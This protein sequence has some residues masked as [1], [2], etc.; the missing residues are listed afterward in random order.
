M[1]DR[2]RNLVDRRLSAARWTPSHSLT[3]IRQIR[4]EIK[5]KKRMTFAT[6]VLIAL[7]VLSAAALAVGSLVQNYLR[8]VGQMS[9]EGAFHSDRWGLN[10]KAR[11]VEAMERAGFELDQAALQK[12]KDADAPAEEREEAA[13]ALILARYGEAMRA[14]AFTWVEPPETIEGMAPE[15]HII[16]RDAWRQENPDATEQQEADALAR[17]MRQLSQQYDQAHPPVTR[18]PLDE[19][20]ADRGA[21]GYLTEV[22]NI[23]YEAAQRAS[24]RSTWHEEERL[25]VSEISLKKQDIGDSWPDQ[26]Y[27]MDYTREEG[28]QYRWTTIVSADG[29]HLGTGSLEDYLKTRRAAPELRLSEEEARQKGREALVARY[30]ISDAQAKDYFVDTR[31]YVL[32]NGD[33]SHP[34]ICYRYKEHSDSIDHTWRYA[35]AV[36]M[37]TGEVRHTF[38]RD[39]WWQEFMAVARD[40]ERYSPEEWH[41]LMLL[42]GT[43][44]RGEGFWAW[45]T[46][47]QMEFNQILKEG[48]QRRAAQTGE[49]A[50]E[51]EWT[52]GR[53]GLP[54][55]GELDYDA[56][57]SRARE[58]FLGILGAVEEGVETWHT[59]RS[60]FDV[61]DPDRHAWRFIIR[62]TLK[63]KTDP[64]G[65]GWQMMFLKLDASSG[66]LLESVNGVVT[67]VDMARLLIPMQALSPDQMAQTAR[68]ALVSR[69]LMDEQTLSGMFV[70][71]IRS[72]APANDPARAVHYFGVYPEEKTRLNR[73]QYAVGIRAATGEV[74]DLF[75]WDELRARLPETARAYPG[76]SPDERHERMMW[77]FTDEALRDFWQWTPEQQ[78]WFSQTVKPYADQLLE[79]EPDYRDWVIDATRRHYG[80][81]DDGA[82]SEQEALRISREAFLKAEAA[83]GPA[84]PYP[85]VMRTYDVSDP[86]RP[87]W[88]VI[89]RADQRLGQGDGQVMR[90]AMRAYVIDALTGEILGEENIGDRQVSSLSRWL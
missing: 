12:I 82:V 63:D 39:G 14:E 89:Q 21:I 55:E 48:V 86:G 34:L 27:M 31:G 9:L 50:L 11:F 81:P 78:R 85:D 74:T 76:L 45:P 10:E 83:R 90:F 66:E 8:E 3:V 53:H 33:P 7:L 84:E 41:M 65:T 60:S 59:P 13:D 68:Q 5:V 32:P 4:G 20:G 15:M 75:T 44:E 26:P 56:A 69:G 64:I 46:Q 25:W 87:L 54:G 72:Y 47:R 73:W 18:P 35:A 36:D 61:S 57:L 62:A 40:Y 1:N 28:D 67:A 71:E 37:N 38:S 6:A 58:A 16:F 19:A 43:D 42:L 22:M 77:Y 80:A 23:P 52:A 17:W 30:G 70:G 51:A 2:F 29:Q 24:V 88:R 79:K 49:W